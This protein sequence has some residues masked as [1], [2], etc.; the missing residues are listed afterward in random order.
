[1]RNDFK[2]SEFALTLVSKGHGPDEGEG[3]E[4]IPQWLLS[5]PA[6]RFFLQQFLLEESGDL[7]EERPSYCF[8][9]YVHY[10]NNRRL[11]QFYLYI[12]YAVFVEAKASQVDTSDVQVTYGVAKADVQRPD[13]LQAY[14][15]RRDRT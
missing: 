4:G 8:S 14:R 3:Y 6:T 5:D 9:H 13:I 11:A 2:P 1:M 10:D 15:P 7:R 12:L